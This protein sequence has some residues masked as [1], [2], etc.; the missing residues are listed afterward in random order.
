LLNHLENVNSS[1]KLRKIIETFRPKLEDFANEV[2]YS[3]PYFEKLVYV[4]SKLKA[5]SGK[6]KGV[7]EQLRIMYLRIKAFKDR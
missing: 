3:K 5:E 1:E 6:Q 2:A 4:D 7:E